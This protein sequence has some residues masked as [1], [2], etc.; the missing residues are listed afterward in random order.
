MEPF[1][2]LLTSFQG[3]DGTAKPHHLKAI[4]HWLPT[5][6]NIV[7]S[8]IIAGLLILTQQVWAKSE[9]TATTNSSGPNAT[10]I[11]YQ[12]YLTDASENPRNGNLPMGFSLW[13]AAV[14]GTKIWGT[15][16][17]TAVP[18]SNGH[19]SVG[20]GSLTAGGIPVTAWDGD[21]YLEIVIGG[22]TLTPRE[23]IRFVSGAAVALT[24]PDEAIGS[25]QIETGAV[26]QEHAPT[27][28]RD[29]D[30]LNTFIQYGQV[31]NA[32]GDITVT[33]PEPF[34][35]IPHVFISQNEAVGGAGAY[36]VYGITPSLFHVM[37]FQSGNYGHVQWLA[38]GQ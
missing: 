22:E 13:D 34:N 16:N 30:N 4:S 10:T 21:R 26:T 23:P 7:F 25:A 33:F 2:H 8:L 19:F 3:T 38:I 32:Q 18:V 1:K 27:L 24:V 28:I 15:E 36:I 37:P 11:N 9:P 35:T 20:L 6:G 5:P 17:H 31:G 12:G 29:S 14:G